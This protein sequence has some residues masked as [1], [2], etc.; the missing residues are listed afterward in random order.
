MSKDE[1][2]FDETK[3]DWRVTGS[4]ADTDNIVFYFKGKVYKKITYPGYKIWNI[5]A[6][7]DDII[8]DF[9]VGMATASSNGLGGSVGYTEVEGV[10]NG[11]N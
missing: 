6:H 4:Y 8:L 10:S 7:L 2:A 9:E 11:T 1:I 3:G 5:A